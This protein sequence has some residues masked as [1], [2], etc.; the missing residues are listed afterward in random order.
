MATR[1]G[2]SAY[3]GYQDTWAATLLHFKERDS[4]HH[5]FDLCRLAELGHVGPADSLGARRVPP[6][7]LIQTY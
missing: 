5:G 6:P 1:A 7:N 4:V 3:L 2:E